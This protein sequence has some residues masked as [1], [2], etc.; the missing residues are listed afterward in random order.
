MKN[1]EWVGKSYHHVA[2]QSFSKGLVILMKEMGLKSVVD[3]GCGQG[4]YIN[5]LNMILGDES[6]LVLRKEFIF[7]EKENC[8]CR[9]LMSFTFTHPLT[10]CLDLSTVLDEVYLV[11]C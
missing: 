10:S 7:Y 2:D 1:V 9:N 5:H 8:F 6:R 4:Q 3:L 11:K